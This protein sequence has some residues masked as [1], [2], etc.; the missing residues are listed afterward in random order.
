MP[1]REVVAVVVVSYNSEEVLCGLIESLPAGLGAVDWSLTVADNASSDRSVTMLRQ[2]APWATVVETGRNA[3][4]AAGI[5][6]AAAAAPSHTALLV[7][8][9]DVRLEPGC[10][11]EL[12][13]ALRQP[14][15]G[16]AVPRLLDAHRELIESMRR[17]PTVL[18]AFGDAFLGARR[19]GRRAA[20]GEM[21]TDSRCYDVERDTDWA[22][23]STQLISEECWRACG[24][25]DESFFLYSEE[26]EYDLRARDHGFAVRYVPTARAQ[27]LEGGSA[28]TPGLWRLLALNRV[29]LFRRRNGWL[30]AIP[31]WAAI[32]LRETSRAVIGRATSR[33][34][35]KALCSPRRWRQPPGPDA[36]L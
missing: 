4:Y 26:A 29:R 9:P 24:P 1:D 2:Q 23:G 14:G 13:R 30:L 36:I 35:A 10:V 31:F 11:P 20:F 32:T 19:A 12:I 18:R 16:I 15:V 17:E 27:H 25:W 8:N 28:G 22:E 34:A 21:V 7:L 5:N 33:E 6:A 3:G